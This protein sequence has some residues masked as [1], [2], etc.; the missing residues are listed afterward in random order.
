M[1]NNLLG[2]TNFPFPIKK[3]TKTDQLIK[4]VT[5]TDQLINEKGIRN[6]T[7]KK[8]DM[9]YINQI[10]S[11]K[12]FVPKESIRNVGKQPKIYSKNSSSHTQKTMFIS[13]FATIF[14]KQF[15]GAKRQ[16]LIIVFLLKL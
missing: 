14:F 4:N 10:L 13:L 9:H 12:I 2:N 11:V 6:V 15:F 3:A 1:M 5:R 7:P 16:C 8:A